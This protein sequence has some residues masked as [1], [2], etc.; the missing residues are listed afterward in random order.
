MPKTALAL[1]RKSRR[2]TEGEAREALARLAASGLSVRVFAER[3]GV[4]AQRFYW[5]RRRLTVPKR[6]RAK[7]VEL[8]PKQLFVA[9]RVELL[10]VSGRVLRFSA[11][12]EGG[13]LRRLVDALEQG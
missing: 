9:E 13:V 5:W 11:T 12:L 3:H 1:Y 6:R 4:D 8:G 2:W 7:F 10:L